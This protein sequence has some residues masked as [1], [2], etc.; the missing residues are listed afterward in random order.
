MARRLF[1]TAALYVITTA[2]PAHAQTPYYLHSENSSTPNFSQLKTTGP[3]SAAVAAQ[4]SDLKN[5]PPGSAPMRWF[6]TQAGVPNLVGTIP[7]GS[8]ISVTLWMKKTAAFGTVYPQATVGLNWPNPVPFCQATGQPNQTPTQALSTTLTPITISCQTATAISMTESDRIYVIAG[9]QMTA[10]PGN[11]SMKVELD[12]EG[13]FPSAT[14]VPNPIPPTPVITSLNPSSAPLNWP[15]T[16]SGSN[17]GQSQGSVKFYNNITATIDS[18]SNTS[19]Q[20]HVPANAVTGPV[21]VTSPS[22]VTSSGSAFTLL[23]PPTLTSLSSSS[24]H[25]NESITITGTNF[26]STQSTSTMKFNGTT[27]T[28]T[29]WS[30]TSIQAPVPTGATSGNVVVTVS[31]QSSNGLPFTVIPPPTVLSAVPSSAQIGASVTISGSYFG[32]SQGS[33]TVTFNNGIAATPTSWSNNRITTTVPTGASTGNIVVNVASQA[34][35]G[36]PFTVLVAGTMGGTVTRVT[37]GT[38]ISGATVHA[39]LTGVVRGTATTAANGTYWISGLD[40]GT[41]DVRIYA[42]GFS[43]ELRQG[44]VLTSTNNTTVNVSMYQPGAVSGRVTQP[45]G[46]T[47]IAG[48]AITVYDGPIQKGSTS[49]NAS[50]DYTV[51]TLRP[52]GYTVQAVYVGYRTSEQGATVSENATATKNFTLS[53]APS[54]PVLYAYDALGRL[55]QVTDQS[56]DSAVYRYDPVGN[57]TSIERAGGGAVSISAFTPTSSAV[58]T[59]VTIN[60]TGFSATP[61]QNTVTFNGLALS[62]TAS[63]ATQIVGTIPAGATT[64]TPYPFVVTTPTGSATSVAA[65]TVLTSGAPSISGVTPATAASGT[66]MSVTGTNF[67]TVTANNNLRVNL[68]PV[69]V[70][71]ATS[72]NLQGSIPPSATAGRVLVSTPNGTATSTD[73]LWVAPPPY[74]ATALD[75]TGTLS[76]GTAATLSVAIN[77]IALR[78]FE[79]TEGHRVSMSLSGITPVF[80]SVSVYLYEPFGTA[81]QTTVVSTATGFMEPV[82]LRSTAT[83]SLVF[84]PATTTQ[85]AGGTITVYDVPADFSDTISPDQTVTVPITKPGQNG[86]LTFAGTAQQRVSLKQETGST[87]INQIA[88]CDVNATILNPDGTVLSPATCMEING[89]IDA[90]D[91]PIAGTYKIVVDPVTTATGN[92]P[93]KLYSFIDVTGPIAFSSP[94]PVSL[95]PGQNARLTFTGAAQQHITLQSS[96]ISGQIFGCDLNVSIVR[97][98]DESVVVPTTCMEGNGFIGNTPLPSAGTYRIVVDPVSFAA[99]TVT[100]T[101]NDVTDAPDVVSNNSGAQP[102]SRGDISAEGAGSTSARAARNLPATETYRVG[103]YRP[104]VISRNF[105][106][107]AISP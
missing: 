37:G 2:V 87:L 58:A 90:I 84:D 49:T 77:K 3:E 94:L 60:G 23:G 74:P 7:S 56:G 69:Q 51:T 32:A 33:S 24:A 70:A 16:I 38:G 14:S 102:L 20:T 54:G 80:S 52:G 55:V 105:G 12:Y 50:G 64:G 76:F 103:V 30:A 96:G 86:A 72:T 31:G 44:I 10:G 5:Q 9:Y 27:A 39:V 28:P 99:G 46:I 88:G 18:W 73:Y 89:F 61:S 83:Y 65:F 19:I 35:N 42:T 6:D 92:L 34:S 26:M 45:D 15:I 36:L 95:V 98:L 67:E 93:L 53:A 104:G 43:T 100:L 11:K 4:T 17:F 66:V 97:V 13:S 106:V 81:L 29:S 25:V 1:W 101:L 63:T 40:P 82:N 85:G 71:S 57:I 48:A 107:S 8:T 68:S 22:N 47:P 59:T 62:I 91:L 75:T 21:T 79:G 78:V 41:Y